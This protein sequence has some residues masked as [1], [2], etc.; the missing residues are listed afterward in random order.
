MDSVAYM[1][2]DTRRVMWTVHGGATQTIRLSLML[3]TNSVKIILKVRIKLS[4]NLGQRLAVKWLCF[5]DS[6]T[7]GSGS[8]ELWRGT[9]ETDCSEQVR[10]DSLPHVNPQHL[11][12]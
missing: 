5:T 6:R 3:R 1:D 8:P 12:H 10:Q 2:D 7:S 11:Q 4:L 9:G